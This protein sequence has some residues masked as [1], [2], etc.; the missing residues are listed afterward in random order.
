M[1]AIFA[2]PARFHQIDALRTAT[3]DIFRDA[4]ASQKKSRFCRKK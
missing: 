3:A 4:A 2:P 1:K